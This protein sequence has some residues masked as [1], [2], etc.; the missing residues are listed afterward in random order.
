MATIFIRTLHN[1][2]CVYTRHFEEA[3]IKARTLCLK[4]LV[5]YKLYEEVSR[6][7]IYEIGKDDFMQV[8][9]YY[10]QRQ[11][12]ILLSSPVE[13]ITWEKFLEKFEIQTHLKWLEYI[14]KK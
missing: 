9:I 8:R 13:V 10:G 7:S 6:A 12:P 1:S 11:P 2:F 14:R 4:P 3:Y 5:S